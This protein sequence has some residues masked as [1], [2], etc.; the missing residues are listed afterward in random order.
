SRL[1]FWGAGIEKC[2]R[3]PFDQ[4]PSPVG[5]GLG[6]GVTRGEPIGANGEKTTAAGK[7][8]RH[9][10]VNQVEWYLDATLAWPLLCC[11]PQAARAWIPLTHV[12][13]QPARVQDTPAPRALV[14]AAQCQRRFDAF[15]MELFHGFH[16]AGNLGCLQRHAFTLADAKRTRVGS[17]H[18][19]RGNPDVV[20]AGD[21]GD[22]SNARTLET[23]HQ[24]RQRLRDMP[25]PMRAISDWF[26]VCFRHA[27]WS[28][29]IR[30]FLVLVH[31]RSW[32]HS[33]FP[34]MPIDGS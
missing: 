34:S 29:T 19:D 27:S 32:A 11:D 6:Q 4:F 26:V 7:G 30:G 15:C 18:D 9:I 17:G 1:L 28:A 23:G 10:Q 8:Y 22:A 12:L 16:D 31:H 25:A 14:V 2:H 20:E 13:G 33:S 21:V 24:L 3:V 5:D